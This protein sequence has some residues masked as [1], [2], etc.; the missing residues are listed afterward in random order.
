MYT[1]QR[2]KGLTMFSS[3]ASSGINSSLSRKTTSKLVAPF[4]KRLVSTLRGKTPFYEMLVLTEK[5]KVSTASIGVPG[6][7]IINTD[8]MALKHEESERSP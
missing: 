6:I 2:L 8:S 7:V 3:P 1:F 4:S 5:G